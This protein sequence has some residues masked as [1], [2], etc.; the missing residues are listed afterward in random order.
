[1]PVSS[2]SWSVWAPERSIRSRSNLATTRGA[3]AWGPA[4]AA[5]TRQSQAIECFGPVCTHWLHHMTEKLH[6]FSRTVALHGFQGLSIPVQA[7]WVATPTRQKR[8]GRVFNRTCLRSLSMFELVGDG[9][10]SVRH[11]APLI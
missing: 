10:R 6:G 2:S 9:S 11:D 7:P 5:F 4:S 8:V 3:G 1:M